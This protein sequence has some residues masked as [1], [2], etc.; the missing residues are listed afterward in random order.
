MTVTIDATAIAGLV[1]AICGALGAALAGGLK[2]YRPMRR[3]IERF[4]LFIE[5]W[6]GEPARY[7]GAVP[8]RPGMMVRVARIERRQVEHERAHAA[9][10]NGAGPSSS[11]NGSVSV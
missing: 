7:D 1:G 9:A 8:E 3:H 4:R 2:V 11:E 10:M 6:E 5:D